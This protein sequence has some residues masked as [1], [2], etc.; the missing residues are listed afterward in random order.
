MPS[1]PFASVISLFCIFFLHV[2]VYMGDA[3]AFAST[4]S[5]WKKKEELIANKIFRNAHL[6]EFSIGF[7][8]DLHSSQSEYLFM[9]A[10]LHLYIVAA[11]AGK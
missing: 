1:L 8:T 5:T 6:L 11:N 9:T 2:M 3:L 4:K 7:S 10:C